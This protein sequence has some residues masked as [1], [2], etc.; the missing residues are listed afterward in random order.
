MASTEEDQAPQQQERAIEPASL[1][2]REQQALHAAED[3]TLY[4]RREMASTLRLELDNEMLALQLAEAK[5]RE[6]HP[7][8]LAQAFEFCTHYST[9][10]EVVVFIH[11]T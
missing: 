8:V 10:E 4:Y 11:S 5:K 2:T 3:R 9:Y 1:F 6:Q 7:T